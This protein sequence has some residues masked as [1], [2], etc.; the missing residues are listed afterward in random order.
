LWAW[1]RMNRRE[2]LLS[3]VKSGDILSWD[4]SDSLK[5]EKKQ[6]TYYYPIHS[7]LTSSQE[8]AVKCFINYYAL[9]IDQLFR[10][11]SLKIRKKMSAW[12]GA[13]Q[14]D[15]QVE[16]SHPDEVYPFLGPPCL[17]SRW[18][19]MFL[20]KRWWLHLTIIS[21]RYLIGA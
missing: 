19:L 1:I 9:E 21:F 10:W 15:Q 5:R 3:V 18:R 7:E 11:E 12:L 4:L 2:A 6:Y 20:K 13:V 8:W 16:S 17:L 14:V